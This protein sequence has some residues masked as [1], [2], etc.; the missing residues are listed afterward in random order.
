MV[1][2]E[3]LELGDLRLLEVDEAVV[4]PVDTQIGFITTSD[5]VIHS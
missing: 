1:P 4:I 5:D 2:T 3:D